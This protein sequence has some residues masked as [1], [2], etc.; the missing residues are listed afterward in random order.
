VQQSGLRNIDVGWHSDQSAE[1]SDCIHDLDQAFDPTANAH[2]A[3]RVLSS[4][5]TRLDSWEDT[6]AAY[7]SATPA[8]GVRYRQQVYASWSTSEGW[9][10]ALAIAPALRRLEKSQ[11]CSMFFQLTATRCVSGR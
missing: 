2:H 6:V 7:H 3:A 10:H 4:L 9:Q 1:P 5:H 8:L 11:I